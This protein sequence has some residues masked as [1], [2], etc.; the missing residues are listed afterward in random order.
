MYWPGTEPEPTTRHDMTLTNL[1]KIN[2][3]TIDVLQHFYN[4]R[5]ALPARRLGDARVDRQA[6]PC[7]GEVGAGSQEQ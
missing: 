2:T 3:L 4:S 6:N 7:A 1:T 5:V